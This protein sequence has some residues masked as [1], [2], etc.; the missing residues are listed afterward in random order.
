V[1]YPATEH[2]P[3]VTKLM[4]AQYFTSVEDGL[5]RA[6]RERPT[7]LERWPAGV[8]SVASYTTRSGLDTRTSRP[9]TETV[10]TAALAI[11]YPSPADR[12]PVRSTARAAADPTRPADLSCPRPAAMRARY[13]AGPTPAVGPP[14]VP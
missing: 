6:L 12:A 9:P 8:R 4:V 7:A 5:M 13:P 10:V 2:T 1:I 11:A 3:E 14:A